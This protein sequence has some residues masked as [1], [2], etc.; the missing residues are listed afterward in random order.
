M[1]IHHRSRAGRTSD[2]VLEMVGWRALRGLSSVL[3]IAVALA[4]HSQLAP[5]V[6]SQAAILYKAGR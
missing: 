6:R 4:H 5:R 2:T 1:V 3:L